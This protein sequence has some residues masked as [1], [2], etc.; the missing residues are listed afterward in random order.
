MEYIIIIFLIIA[1][2]VFAA[3]WYTR[4][5]IKSY[6]STKAKNEKDEVIKQND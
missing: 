4:R 1:L 2:N 5:Q 6:D 3:I